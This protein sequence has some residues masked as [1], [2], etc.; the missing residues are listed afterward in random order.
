MP[1]E[2]EIKITRPGKQKVPVQALHP[3]DSRQCAFLHIPDI[4]WSV[5]GSTAFL[6]YSNIFKAFGRASY[7]SSEVY[8]SKT[9]LTKL[10]RTSGTSFFFKSSAFPLHI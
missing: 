7:R 8:G 10:Y 1:D 6:L 4:I 9:Y 2:N 3:F 5:F